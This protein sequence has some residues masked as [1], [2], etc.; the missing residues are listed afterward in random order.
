[1]TGVIIGRIN[2]LLIG[3]HGDI[4]LASL[5]V[6]CSLDNSEIR[7]NFVVSLR[8]P[9]DVMDVTERINVDDVDERG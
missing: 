5:A 1:M 8:A 3:G 6:V 4:N 9:T 2:I 7:F